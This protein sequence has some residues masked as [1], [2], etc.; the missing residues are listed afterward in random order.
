LRILGIGNRYPPESLGGYEFIWQRA[1]E[2]FREHGHAVRV[3]TSDEGVSDGRV[4]RVEGGVHRELR[5]YWHDHAFPKLGRIALV[6][7]ERDNAA[8]LA[9][10][11]EAFAPDVI[12]WWAM[13]GMSLSLIEQVRRARVPALGVVGDNWLNYARD[14]DWWI[15]AWGCRPRTRRIAERVVGVPTSLEIGRAARWHFISAWLRDEALAYGWRLPD[16][17]VTH[18]G[19]RPELS[20]RP[21]VPWSG[22]LLYAGRIDPR[23][24]IATAVDAL[25]M[26]EAD[27]TLSIDGTGDP[28]HELELRE[29]V[30]DAG[31]ETRVRF[32]RTPAERLVD[33]Y[34]KAD[35]VI[36][37]V[38]WDEPWGLVP[39]EAMT[40]GT[41]VI[42]T[43]T[44][45]AAEYLRDGVNCLL[46]GAG[47]AAAL[48][49]R[50]TRLRQDPHLRSRLR[51]GGL[52]TAARY[53][54]SAF[55]EALERSARDVAGRSRSP[56]G[57]STE[58]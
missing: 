7:H 5:W 35:A 56:I 25:G 3:L 46:F 8:V 41:P 44:G 40:V 13:G 20:Q 39:L 18:P 51:E 37:P 24:G 22:R 42:A 36:F 21:E 27:A 17:A 16:V 10:H 33:M 12:T 6:R 19:V 34:A 52:E 11:L 58:V 14:V 31:V 47:D 26:L 2:T 45:G 43:A 49:A 15:Q 29:R 50:V 30:I 53:P 54:E 4:A 32:V 57:C 9:G 1:M 48:A 38:Q 28:A 23:K 55:H